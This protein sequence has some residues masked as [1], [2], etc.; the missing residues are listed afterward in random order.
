[1]RQTGRTSPDTGED[2]RTP[3]DMLA[4]IAKRT[5]DA[6]LLGV[7]ISGFV[8]AI[9]MLALIPG[10]IT[11][12]LPFVTVGAFGLWGIAEH[13]RSSETARS[14]RSALSMF[15]FVVVAAG[16]SAILLLIFAIAGRAIGT[17]IS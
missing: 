2:Q 17:I 6:T 10:Q 11:F 9:V 16:A 3:L 8:A 14:I 4:A 13:R 12:A 5:P 1:M 7:E 15:Q